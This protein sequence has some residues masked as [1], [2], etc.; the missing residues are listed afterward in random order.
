MSVPTRRV[1]DPVYGSPIL[2]AGGSGTAVWNKINTN[3][4]WQNGTGWQACL[5]G[6]A[7]SGDDWGAAFFPVN[8]DVLVSEFNETLTT[9][10]KYYMTATQTMGVNIVIWVHDPNNLSKRAEITQIGGNSL[11]GKTA[12]WNSHKLLNTTTQFVWYGEDWSGGSAAALSGSDLTSGTQ[13]TWN[14]FRA[15][16]LFSNYVI[17]RV[18]LESGWEASGTFQSVWVTNAMFNGQSVPIIPSVQEIFAADTPLAKLAANSGV[19][20]GDVTLNA[21]TAEIGKL[22]AGVAL[23]GKVGIDQTT[24]GTTNRV[25]IGVDTG[26]YTTPTA[27]QPSI[28]ATTTTALAAN[29][30]RLYAL[31]VNDSVETLYIKLGAAA[32]LNQGIRLNANGGSYEIS[33]KFGNLYT[34]AINGIGTSGA[35][36]LL[37][38][39][40]V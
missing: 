9:Q 6:G 40:G 22:A 14:Q 25:D 5:T 31:L 28:A 2:R 3:S 19:D 26:S 36:V 12:G 29:A 23:I 17:C 1:L 34:G 24:P 18:S 30:N 21:G 10:W 38:T 27:T 8:S 13:Y 20:I 33:K 15:D 39:E 35:A 11:L 7:Q 16:K 4:Q 37:V 32:V